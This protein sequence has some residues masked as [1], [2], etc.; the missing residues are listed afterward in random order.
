MVVPARRETSTGDSANEHKGLGIVW[1][2]GTRML[3][4]TRRNVER[5]PVN[6][7]TTMRGFQRAPFLLLW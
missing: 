2:S 1:N 6:N 4:Q 7:F 5:D 3:H